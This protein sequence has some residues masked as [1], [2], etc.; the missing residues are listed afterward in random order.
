M[1][2][3]P[4]F[5]SHLFYRTFPLEIWLFLDVLQECLGHNRGQLVVVE[6]AKVEARGEEGT[7]KVEAARVVSRQHNRELNLKE[8]EDLVKDH[9][10]GQKIHHQFTPLFDH[11]DGIWKHCEGVVGC[12]EIRHIQ[13]G[14]VE[15][16][17]DLEFCCFYF[18]S[19]VLKMEKFEKNFFFIH[20]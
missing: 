16:L 17:F 20:K 10:E 13:V 7:V 11:I 1:T 9:F 12:I 15:V 18:R 2:K 3:L 19:A 5:S 8:L 14:K 4:V 6:G